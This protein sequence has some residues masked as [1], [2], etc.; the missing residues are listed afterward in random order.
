MFPVK[1]PDMEGLL[2]HILRLCGYYKTYKIEKGCLSLSLDKIEAWTNV[3]RSKRKKE[4][5]QN[6]ITSLCVL[7]DTAEFNIKSVT[8]VLFYFFSFWEMK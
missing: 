7:A 3:P 4:T 6:K 1:F 5:P 2:C 8:S